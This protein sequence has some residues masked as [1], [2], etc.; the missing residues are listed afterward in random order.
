[1]SVINRCAR[2]EGAFRR[3]VSRVATGLSVLM[4][5]GDDATVLTATDTAVAPATGVPGQ[6]APSAAG[7]STAPASPPAPQA[8][9]APPAAQPNLPEP[10]VPPGTTTGSLYVLHSTIDTADTRTGYLVTTSSIE[11]DVSLEVTDGVEVPG[12][13]YLYAPPDGAFF[14]MGGSEQPTFTRYELS[15]SGDLEERGAVSFASLGVQSTHRHVIFHSPEKAYFLDESQLQVIAFNPKTMELLRAI[16]VPGF[17][18]AEVETSFGTPVRRD[19]GYYFP[20]GCWDLDVTSTGTSLVH[21][22]PATD[23]L[24]VTHDARCMGMQIGFMADTGD[25]YWFSDHDASV[26][27]TY[28]RRSAPH[29]CALRLRAGE[30]TFDPEWELDLTTRTGGVSA[31][32]AVPAGGGKIWMKVFDSAA[33]TG[34]IPV[35]EIDWGLQVWRWG[36]LD[37]EATGPI[38]LNPVARLVVSYGYPIEVDGRSFSPVS[39]SDYSETTLIE[40]ADAGI[41][42]RIHVQGELRKIVRLR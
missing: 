2:P 27:W 40:L 15:S 5:C 3:H 16:A 10:N 1:M 30:T 17:R 39:N 19:D 34:T 22:D 20:R 8:A 41:E 12:G 35:E 26:E 25:A 24:T 36:L 42:E 14:L 28:Q 38:Q 6:A 37:V 29:D 18:C 11:A 32:A 21:L 13:G 33:F 7:G 4:A 23:E 31:V 9:P